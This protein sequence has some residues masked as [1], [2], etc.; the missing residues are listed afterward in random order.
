MYAISATL[1]FGDKLNRRQEGHMARQE[2]L[3]N[4]KKNEKVFSAQIFR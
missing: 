3:R 2:I 1:M 4:V